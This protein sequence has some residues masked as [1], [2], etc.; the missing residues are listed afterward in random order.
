M[1]TSPLV[2]LGSII[3]T[4]F[5]VLFGGLIAYFVPRMI[6]RE[7]SEHGTGGI[8]VDRWLRILGIVVMVVGIVQI[9]LM[10]AL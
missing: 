9:V 1:E 5:I 4:L 8:P 3:G 10:L 2:S 6:Q 7:G